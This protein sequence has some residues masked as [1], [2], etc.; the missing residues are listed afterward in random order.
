M[1][2]IGRPALALLHAFAPAVV[3]CSF[4]GAAWPKRWTGMMALVRGV[5]FRATAAGSML[6]VRGSMSA[7]TIF[8]PI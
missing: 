2:R 1:N 5:I 4:I 7:K 3:L 8:A 6:N